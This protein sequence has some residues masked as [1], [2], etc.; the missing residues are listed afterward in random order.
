MSQ[1]NRERPSDVGPVSS[2]APIGRCGLALVVLSALSSVPLRGQDQP[3]SGRRIELSLEPPASVTIALAD[4]LP[5][6]FDGYDALVV[7]FPDGYDAI[8]VRR[9][10]ASVRVLDSAMRMLLRMRMVHLP[11]NEAQHDGVSRAGVFA[12]EA[13]NEAWKWHYDRRIQVVLNE[14]ADA[15]LI[16]VPSLGRLRGL[17]VIPPNMIQWIVP[18]KLAKPNG[19]SW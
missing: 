12:T 19:G 7:R 11:D 10:G 17:T 15:P 18:R 2:R 3:Q 13:P 5:S 8:V 9:L 6:P 14:L 1:T 4:S 16:Q